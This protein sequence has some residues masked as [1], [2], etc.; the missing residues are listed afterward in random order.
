[1]FTPKFFSNDL[2]RWL[3]S[4][5][6]N[7]TYVYTLHALGNM[8]L[9][10]VW[11]VHLPLRVDVPRRPIV[12]VQVLSIYQLLQRSF[13]V[14]CRSHFIHFTSM[15]YLATATILSPRLTIERAVHDKLLTF[16]EYTRKSRIVCKKSQA[17]NQGR[18]RKNENSCPMGVYIWSKNEIFVSREF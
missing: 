17:K 4:S 5:T 12:Q 1:M 2:A 3:L 6:I 14:P 18:G 16:L 13:I 7:A 15:L 8:T 11:F 9:L 10:S